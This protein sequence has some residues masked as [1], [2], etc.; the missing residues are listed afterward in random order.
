M[1]QK[2][3]KEII[4]E[5]RKKACQ[6][7]GYPTNFNN[8][9]YIAFLF[10]WLH[11]WT[12]SLKQQTNALCW[13]LKQLQMNSTSPATPGIQ[14]IHMLCAEYKGADLM[15]GLALS[16][17]QVERLVLAYKVSPNQTEKY[18]FT[19]SGKPDVSSLFPSLNCHAE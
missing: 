4:Q 10:F 7:A 15:K 3:A 8:A 6:T 11:V 13:M 18:S 14:G 17:S 12:E 5:F 16:R 19:T 1:L 2:T 9:N